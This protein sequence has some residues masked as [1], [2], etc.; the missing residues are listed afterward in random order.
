MV[1]L[2]TLWRQGP[3]RVTVLYSLQKEPF[4]NGSMVDILLNFGFCVFVPFARYTG[5]HFRLGNH[6]AEVDSAQKEE[7]ISAKEAPRGAGRVLDANRLPEL[8][9]AG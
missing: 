2:T 3:E 1:S 7:V 9:A 5:E 6:P 4:T 8:W